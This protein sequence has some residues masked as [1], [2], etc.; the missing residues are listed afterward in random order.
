MSPKKYTKETYPHDRINIMTGEERISFAV[1]KGWNAWIERAASE[2]D[3]DTSKFTRNA[4]REYFAH[5][6]NEFSPDL[7]RELDRLSNE[8]DRPFSDKGWKPSIKRASH[9]L[10]LDTSKFIRRALYRYILDT[11][12]K[13]SPKLRRELDQLSEESSAPFGELPL[14]G[15]R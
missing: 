1:G 11:E 14:Q 9:E 4:L 13:L 10:G 7:K 6:Q 15:A 8:S 3:S 2:R 12:R 5:N